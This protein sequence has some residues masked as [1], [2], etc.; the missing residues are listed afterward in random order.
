MQQE[1]GSERES[2]YN[3]NNQ[4]PRHVRPFTGTMVAFWIFLFGD[5]F[6]NQPEQ[7]T[8]FCFRYHAADNFWSCES[9][10]L[11]KIM[12]DMMIDLENAGQNPN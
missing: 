7:R 6:K 4:E 2:H 1:Q 3:E 8:P 12:I 10:E 5:G 9:P 11:W